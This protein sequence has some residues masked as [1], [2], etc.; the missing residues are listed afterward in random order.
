MTPRRRHKRTDPLTS[1]RSENR[2]VPQISRQDPTRK[3]TKKK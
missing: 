3:K 1:Q 2:A